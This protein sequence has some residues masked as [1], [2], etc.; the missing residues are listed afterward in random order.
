MAN[1]TR[2]TPQDATVTT[3][4]QVL[5]NTPPTGSHNIATDINT[6]TQVFVPDNGLGPGPQGLPCVAI[7]EH[8]NAQ[9]PGFFGGPELFQQPGG[10]FNQLF[11]SFPDVALT[12]ISDLRL[13]SPYTA[14]TYSPITIGVI[15]TLTGTFKAR[16]FQAG[17]HS[18][19]PLTPLKP[20][21]GTVAA[22]FKRISIPAVAVFTFGNPANFPNRV[23]Q[24]AIYTDRYHFVDNL[25]LVSP[26]EA[27][28]ELT[29]VLEKI[30]TPLK[31]KK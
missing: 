17:P 15:A 16:W 25:S 29:K 4:F 26:N 19:S 11:T 13:Y 3:F 7:T 21:A 1:G 31:K 8:G 10:L 30:T 14:P 12:P 28:K 22:P 20:A 2:T 6:L 9:G 24:L 5:T 27:K 18:S 23:T